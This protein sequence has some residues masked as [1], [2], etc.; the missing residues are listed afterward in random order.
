[1]LNLA[2]Y[3]TVVNGELS[4]Q[5]ASGMPIARQVDPFFAGLLAEMERFIAR[6]GKRLRPYLLYLAYIGA[7]GT[8]ETKILPIA[9]ALEILHN[10]LL[11]HDDIIDRDL[12][13]YG[14]LNIQGAY[15]ERLHADLQPAKAERHAAEI[16]LLAGDVAHLLSSRAVL[17]APLPAELLVKVMQ[18]IHEATLS[19]A[20]GELIDSL[21]PLHLA[22]L[23]ADEARIMRIY[24]YKT[25]SYTF[26]LPIRLGVLLAG[27]NTVAT[28]RAITDCAQ[29]LGIAYQLSDDLLGIFGNEAQTGKPA[30][31]DILEGR[32]TL[33]R[34]FARKNLN[35]RS[36]DILDRTYGNSQAT[37]ID[38]AAVRQV[39]E[40]EGIRADVERLRDSYFDQA[41]AALPQIGLNQEV[42]IQLGL[43]ITDI[44]SRVS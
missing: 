9:A 35:G 7:G 34:H 3:R 11:I 21:L 2:E 29:P 44:R 4:R 31:S 42:S 36:A 23:E 25:A 38:V 16:A 1:M 24:T 19:V 20:G 6:G 37:A 10:F 8:E 30:D 27:G 41:E 17:N 22:E 39:L 14:A 5:Y 33:L 26:E 32:E 15:L 43:L 28:E 40:T 12:I 18:I 13:R